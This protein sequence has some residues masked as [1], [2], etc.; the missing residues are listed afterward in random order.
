MQK[1]IVKGI[2]TKEQE[3]RGLLLAQDAHTAYIMQAGDI[4]FFCSVKTPVLDIRNE[5]DQILSGISFEREQ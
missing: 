4:K 2:L 1:T 5:A 3:A